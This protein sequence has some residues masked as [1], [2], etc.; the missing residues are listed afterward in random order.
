VQQ[1]IQLAQ[2]G[3][4]A[5]VSHAERVLSAAWVTYVQALRTPPKDIEFADPTLLSDTAADRILSEAASSPL[6]DRHIAVT[7]NVNP[8]YAQLREAAWNIGRIT[9]GAIDQRIVRNLDRLRILP[10]KGRYVVVDLASQTL[11]M[12]AEGSVRDTMKV[13]VG[14]PDHATR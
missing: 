13:I 9:G 3:T 5:A 7:S 1:A 12:Y 4:P 8:T 14:K 2:T 10:S 6:L 11:F